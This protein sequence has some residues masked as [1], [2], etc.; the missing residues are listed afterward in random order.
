[1]LATVENP[2][3]GRERREF[4]VIAVNCWLGYKVTQS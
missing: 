2:R 1:M 4:H 3:V